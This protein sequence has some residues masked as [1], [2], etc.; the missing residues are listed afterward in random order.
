MDCIDLSTPAKRLKHIL[1][2]M[3]LSPA[4]VEQESGGRVTA[5][6]V[7]NWLAGAEPGVS[8]ADALVGWLL[9]FNRSLGPL[10]LDESLLDTRYI[11]GGQQ[12]HENSIGPPKEKVTRRAS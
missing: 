2:R 4:K 8:R 1:T 3:G 11:W 10:S 5:Y 7:T 6:Q 12:A 9:D